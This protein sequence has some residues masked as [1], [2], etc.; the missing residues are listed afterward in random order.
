MESKTENFTSMKELDALLNNERIVNNGSTWNK[1]DKSK[2][3]QKMQ[4]FCET[5][6]QDDETRATVLE[7]LT[8]AI[9]NGRLSKVKDVTYNIS[10]QTI[11]EIP[12]LAQV[13]GNYILKQEKRISASKSL[14]SKTRLNHTKKK[15]LKIDN[16]DL[17]AI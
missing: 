7:I 2:K 10:N 12:S 8:R 4:F 11:T 6:F 9:D 3:I 13:E 5:Q 17:T 16:K 15:K 1:L 14:P